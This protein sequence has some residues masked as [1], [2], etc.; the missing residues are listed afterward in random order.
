MASFS[1]RSESYIFDGS[2]GMRDQ[3][4]QAILNEFQKKNYPLQATVKNV[5]AGKGLGGMM[6][7]SKEQC[8]VV[9]V[10]DGYQICISNTT[11]GT[12]LYVGIYL[13]VP[14]LTIAGGAASWASQINDV[15]K[16]QKI[17]AY[18]GVAKEITESAFGA[19]GLKQINSGYTSNKQ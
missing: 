10:A 18:Y 12:Y 19:L 7:G 3:L 17:D 8:V 16:L 13:M 15:F 5:K 1:G 14:S 2:G 4:E 11:V 6:F 9:D